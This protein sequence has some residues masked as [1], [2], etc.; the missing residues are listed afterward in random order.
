MGLLSRY[1]NS[2]LFQNYENNNK[3]APKPKEYWDAYNAAKTDLREGVQKY[4][5]YLTAFPEDQD[6]KISLCW[7]LY[8]INKEILAGE[9][10][11]RA[12]KEFRENL[13]LAIYRGYCPK[14]DRLY[15]LFLQ[16][17]YK[18]SEKSDSLDYLRFLRVWGI[19]NLS[20]Q[21]WEGITLAGYNHPISSPAL[22]AAMKAGKLASSGDIKDRELLSLALSWVDE[23]IKKKP[24]EIWLP[25][26]KGKILRLLGNVEQAN[27]YLLGVLKA[28]SSE[29]WAWNM[30]S[31]I[32]EEMGDPGY[33]ALLCKAA[34]LINDEKLGRKIR[35]RLAREMA[36]RGFYAEA[37]R[38]ILIIDDTTAHGGLK[39]LQDVEDLKYSDWYKETTATE[40]NRDFYKPYIQEADEYLVSDSP[41][42]DAVIGEAY[43]DKNKKRKINIFTADDVYHVSQSRPD[44]RSLRKGTLVS[45]KVLKT[46][47]TTTVF[48]IAPREGEAWDVLTR[49][50]GIVNGINN[51]KGSFTVVL[52][53]LKEVSVSFSKKKKLSAELGDS[54]LVYYFDKKSSNK[55]L[56]GQYWEKSDQEVE[57]LKKEFDET[58]KSFLDEKG[59]GFTDSGIFIKANICKG[60][61]QSGD[62]VKGVSVKTYNRRKESWGWSAIS[63][64]KCS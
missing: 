25:W 32:R 64:D 18:F 19:E 38:E 61:I 40:S 26:Y 60:K 48:K 13:T 21:S 10:T 56:H 51:E 7:C 24:E 1:G 17:A 4:K 41:W 3:R 28:K 62:H 53:N 44:V 47:V 16:Q 12:A 49:E 9:I 23:A 27:D 30:F 36:S 14:E 8:K 55:P 58:V 34:S 37:K 63:I 22:K 50:V 29:S 42:V 11:Y 33:F 35:Y 6:A 39:I 45:I 15:S 57:S 2:S 59:Y 31:L 5:E 46:P 54:V 20:A 43:E 52:P